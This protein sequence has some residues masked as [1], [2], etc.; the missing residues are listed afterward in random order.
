MVVLAQG[1]IRHKPLAPTFT[2]VPRNHPFFA[3]IETA[4]KHGAV[5]GYS[6]GTFRPYSDMTRGQ[7][8]KVIVL[9]AGWSLYTPAQPTFTDVSPA[10]EFYQH[11]E[12]AFFNGIVSGYADGTFRPQNY[13]T[14][15]QVAKIMHEAAG[16]AG[17]ARPEE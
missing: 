7:L 8:C 9:A 15:G 6:D 4:Y 3:Y 2:D 14:R 10:N 16:Q 13:A 12:T 11:I 5:T 17:V 1:W